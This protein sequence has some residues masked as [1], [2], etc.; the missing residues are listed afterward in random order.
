MSRIIE[1]NESDLPQM[2]HRQLVYKV[3]EVRRFIDEAIIGYNMIEHNQDV[4]TGL[5]LLWNGLSFAKA[6]NDDV[7]MQVKGPDF[8]DWM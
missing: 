5:F 1:V 2:E 3:N 6:C 8:I 7:M 4:E